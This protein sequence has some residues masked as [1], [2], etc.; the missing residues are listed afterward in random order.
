MWFE[1]IVR[2]SV[3]QALLHPSPLLSSNSTDPMTL[4]QSPEATQARRWK[5]LWSARSNFPSSILSQFTLDVVIYC[6]DPCLVK[7][8]A[9]RRL[10]L[11]RQICPLR[12]GLCDFITK[13]MTA[14]TANVPENQ[15]SG[16]WELSFWFLGCTCGTLL[17]TSNVVCAGAC[18]CP[19]MSTASCCLHEVTF[20]STSGFWGCFFCLTSSG[21]SV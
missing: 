19:T 4:K 2:A 8:K 7:C 6:I 21:I 5:L 12:L 13:C 14:Q 10:A 18:A 9:Q 17:H 3:E 15:N 11:L 20:L 16:C 1:H